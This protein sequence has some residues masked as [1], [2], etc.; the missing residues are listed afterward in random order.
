[1]P[2]NKPDTIESLL[3][4]SGV[5]V[6]AEQ[7]IQRVLRGEKLN[8]EER[9]YVVD[10]VVRNHPHVS[11]SQMA[12][13][14]N[15][16]EGTIRYDIKKTKTERLDQVK[17]D[18]NLNL[19][20]ADLLA[21]RDRVLRNLAKA[22]KKMEDQ[23]NIDNKTY[24]TLNAQYLKVYLD[25][26]EK[27]QGMGVLPKNL[28]SLAV[29]QVIYKSVVQTKSGAVQT[30]QVDFDALPEKERLMLTAAAER[31]LD[32][33]DDVRPGETL[34]EAIE[35][36]ARAQT[37]LIKDAEFEVVTATE[38][39]ADGQEET[40]RLPDSSGAEQTSDQHA[41]ESSTA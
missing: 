37:E 27:L 13:W 6:E 28:G 11:N 1:M 22:M 20:I 3:P 39:T 36:K 29:K 2:E 5:L 12:R 18:T 35:R 40:T 4:Q 24:A 7:L 25:V 26:T 34:Q 41:Q 8:T 31:P 14:L 10:Y 9:R 15:V 38:D 30:N 21:A 17:E 33:F 19:I 32:L 23:Q 16:D